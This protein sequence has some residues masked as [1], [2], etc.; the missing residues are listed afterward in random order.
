MAPSV[1]TSRRAR[2]VA[3]PSLPVGADLPAKTDVSAPV[4]A[5]VDPELAKAIDLVREMGREIRRNSDN[6][7]RKFP[8]E[9]RK[10]HYGEVEPRAIVGEATAAEARELVEEGIAFQPLPALPEEQ[11]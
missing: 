3:S 1:Q 11:N 2:K 9:A 10:I 5:G 8:E 7:G 4:A 6:V